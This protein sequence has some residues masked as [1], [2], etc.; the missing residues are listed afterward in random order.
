MSVRSVINKAIDKKYYKL[1]TY[2]I[3]NMLNV[4]NGH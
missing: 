1:V 3:E 4:E 2:L